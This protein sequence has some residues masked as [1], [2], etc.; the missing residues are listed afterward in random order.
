VP[1]RA[2]LTSIGFEHNLSIE[3]FEIEPPGPGEV[4]VRVEACGVCHRD[5]I[6]RG[7]R[8]PWLQVPITPG[9]EVC[10][11][12]EA[13]GE[14]VQSWRPGDRVGTLHRDHC[15]A[16]PACER[17]ESSLCPNGIWV[18]GLIADGGYATHLKARPASL[19]KLPDGPPAADL[20]AMHCTA[21]TAYRGLV[22]Q[23]RLAAGQTVLITGANGGVG[24]AAI[25]VAHRLGAKVIAQVRRPERVEFVTALGADQVLVDDGTSFH[26]KLSEQVDVVLDCVG[27]PTF[28]SSLRCARMGGHVVVVGNVS[29][30]RAKLNLGYAIV[31]G[32]HI[33]GSSG[34]TAEDMAAL[35]ELHAQEPLA[36]AQLRDQIM[37]LARADAA[38]RAIRAGGLAGRIVL[39]CASAD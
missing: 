29:T 18:Y 20:C 30:E 6:D 4:L 1:T 38:Q 9:H 34:A 28:N 23:G 10:G 12:I 37:P 26:R 22:V 2:R 31:H 15:G 35:L 33:H 17:G 16:C 27:S 32:L 19:F 14:G 24:A 25:Q 5:L 21:G 36:L 7:G 8:F 13:V 3:S 11:R 39:D